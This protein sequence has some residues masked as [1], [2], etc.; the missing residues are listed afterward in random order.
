MRQKLSTPPFFDRQDAGEQL[1]PLLREYE[2]AADTLVLALPRGGIPVAY[3]IADQLALPLDV[4][5]VRKLGV[6]W[7]KELAMGAVASGGV[8]IR[9][10]QLILELHISEESFNKVLA[11]EEK[12][13][14]HREKLYHIRAE[15]PDLENKTL[16][17]VDDGI[18]TGATMEVAVIA[19]KEHY[20][21]AEIIIVTPVISPS[22]YEAL[23]GEVNNIIYL[24]KPEHFQAVGEW[25]ADF[26]QVTDSEAQSLLQNF[27]RL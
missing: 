11:E 6:S 19:L 18:A 24:Y 21:P 4:F 17:L 23:K 8:C 14:A 26:T 9:N 27:P 3:P 20:H 5:L 16:L 1:V 12:E 2:A 13:L 7:N 25:Y 22:A 10:D 15:T